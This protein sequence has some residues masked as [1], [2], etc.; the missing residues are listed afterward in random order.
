M[1]ILAIIYTFK[2]KF[3][4]LRFI[5]ESKKVLRQ[6]KSVYAT[7]LMTLASHIGAGNIVGVTTALIYGGPGSLFWMWVSCLF[8]SIF[9]LIENTLAVKYKETINGENRGGSSYYIHKGLHKPI[10][11]IIFS[12]FLVL[13]STIF[14][15]PIQV[16]TVAQSI[17]IP[18]QVSNFFILCLLLLTALLIIFRG[19]KKILR[20]IEIIV[21]IMTLC[22]LGI[23]IITIVFNIKSIPG[24]FSIILKDAFT[25][26]S[27]KGALIGGALIIGLKRSSF[28]NEAG[29]GTAPS[30]SAMSENKSSISQAYVQ[31]FGVFVD[32]VLMCTLMGLMILLYDINLTKYEGAS[33]AI[34]IFEVIFGKFG[35]YLGAFFLF[36]FALATWVSSYYAGES[37]MLYIIKN[38]KLTN[39]SAI[40]IY[41]LIYLLGTIMGIYATNN[42]LWDFVDYGII[43]LG[44]INTYAILK[45]E[46][47]FQNELRIYFKNENN[48]N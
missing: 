38:T 6:N 7:F 14:F 45:L 30:I 44:I 26:Q 35:F 12:G 17:K 13:N 36:T 5:T 16:N 21:P 18:F 39:K 27:V 31:V 34:Y 41:Q 15:G 9:S 3:I 46:K 28:S 11:A 19:T 25:F 40:H 4:Q 2:Y 29:L 43:F 37:N 22:F 24:V 8:T 20:F 48:V 32:T 10:L 23:A 47:E 33:L 42:I 1:F